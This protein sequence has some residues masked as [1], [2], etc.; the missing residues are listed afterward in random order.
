MVIG[1]RFSGQMHKNA[2]PWANRYIGNPILS[3]MLRWFFHTPI[4][5]SH[6]GMRSFTAGAYKRMALRT[7]G[8]EFASEM[9]VRA[10]QERLKIKEIPISYAPRLGESK[11]NP[12][13]DAPRH[14]H[15][16]IRHKCK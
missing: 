16:L 11:L 13:R 2:M 5:D 6:C 3:G 12:I 10:A 4:S 9:V 14:I 15:F 1:N 8:M 7:T